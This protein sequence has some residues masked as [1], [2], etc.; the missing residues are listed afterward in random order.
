MPGAI[1]KNRLPAALR[2]I[3]LLSVGFC[4]GVPQLQ[5]QL[6]VTEVMS[7]ATTNSSGGRADFWELTNFGSN[8]IDLTG[9][10][11][12]DPDHGP[13]PLPSNG[14]LIGPSES[15]VFFRNVG[16]IITDE[17]QFR[18]WWGLPESHP[19]IRGYASPGLSST[20]DTLRVYDPNAVLIDEVKFGPSLEG[21]SF[22]Y[23]TNPG[24]LESQAEL[25]FA[26]LIKPKRETS[27]LGIS[28]G[29]T[30]RIVVSA[31]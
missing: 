31:N 27:Q 19:I 22:G 6:A 25:V 3:V 5:A 13:A 2:T 20:G 8:A 28:C 26:V 23:D 29:R 4:V 30:F 12:C 17:A 15:V 1:F 7:N 18:S 24:T 16:G 14:L 9:Y 11:F 21:V 10:K